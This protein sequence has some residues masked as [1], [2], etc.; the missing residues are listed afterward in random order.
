M[1][2]ILSDKEIE[3]LSFEQTFKRLEETISILENE[4]TDLEKSIELFDLGI[5][6]KNHCEKKLKT[7][8]M[9]I[10]KVSK[11]N[12]IENFDKE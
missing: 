4:S 1:I 10:K 8:E 3:K 6:L 9:K 11:E 5:K 2:D 12:Q 7:A